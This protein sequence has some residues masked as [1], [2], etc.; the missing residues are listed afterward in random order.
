[1]HLIPADA[2]VARTLQTM[3][4]GQIVRLGGYLVE[5]SSTKHSSG[6]FVDLMILGAD[7]K[8]RR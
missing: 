4:R 5:L 1:M 2:A 7:G 8:F 6:K 3:R